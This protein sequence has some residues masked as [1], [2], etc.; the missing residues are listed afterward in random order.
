M[1]LL[2]PRKAAPECWKDWARQALK[3]Q[4]ANKFRM[5][6]TAS[7]V[8]S[9]L[10]LFLWLAGWWLS[11]LFLL[12]SGPLVLA[13]FVVVAA[14]LDGCVLRPPGGSALGR[15]LVKLMLV[16]I[17]GWL[18]LFGVVGFFFS[19]GWLVHTLAGMDVAQPVEALGQQLTG[20]VTYPYLFFSI[21]VFILVPLAA[22]FTQGL[23]PWLSIWFVLPL[24]LCTRL[25][26]REAYQL[27]RR[28]ETRN[29]GAVNASILLSLCGL[30]LILVSGGV[31]AII[32]L[33]FLGA[34]QYVS[35]KDIFLPLFTVSV[36]KP[37]DNWSYSFTN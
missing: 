8:V 19:I 23:I 36:N 14:R 1:K 21:L 5:L 33:P 32:V 30:S 10:V 20:Q 29:W 31:L 3:L 27:S 28:G 6:A 4:S 11:L 22:Y 12:V 13:V 16:G 26:L 2:E 15:T 17:V 25:E 7:V 37:V 34:Y 35:F 18:A 9:L 24:L